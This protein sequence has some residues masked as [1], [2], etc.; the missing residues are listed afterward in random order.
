ME[1]GYSAE[2]ARSRIAVGCN[3]MSMPGLEYTLNDV[4]KINIAKVFEV[5]F[6]ES[7]TLE[8]LEQNYR[9]HFKAAVEVTA[10]GIDFHLEHQYLNEPE[11]LLNL[12]SH[13]PIEKGMDISHGG[14]TY[15]NM[16]IDGAGLAVVA[17]SF[18][19]IEERVA[20]EGVLT[21]EEVKKAVLADFAGEEGER[22]QKLLS[23]S[24]RYGAGGTAADRWAVKLTEILN[25]G[26]AGRTT[27]AGHKLIPGWFT[28]ADTLRFGK[29]VGATPNGRRAGEPI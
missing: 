5:A 14:A 29:S 7:S 26:I 28:W 1:N 22:V 17:D 27:P 25:D 9:R 6:A 8:E 10:K 21:F 19:A 18:G 2:L 13:G 15:Y 24:G 12:V 3:W 16:A 4:V 23:A 11:L 20:K